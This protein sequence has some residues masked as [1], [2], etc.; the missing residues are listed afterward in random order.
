VG[1]P[2]IVDQFGNEI[3]FSTKP[4]VDTMAELGRVRDPWAGR[5]TSA[6]TP[7]SLAR[8]LRGDAELSD[9]MMLCKQ[10]LRDPHLTACMRNLA[11]SIARLPWEVLPFDESADAK[12]DAKDFGDF[13]N[14]LPF[15]QRMIRQLVYGEFYTFVGVGLKWNL[16]YGLDGF[17]PIDPPRWTWDRPTNSLRLK[18][19]AQ[20]T[21]GEPINARAFVLHNASLEPGTVRDAGLWQKSAWLWLFKNTTW[22]YWVRF[23]ELFG[24]PYIWAFFDRPEDKDSVLEAVTGMAANARGAFPKGTE[25]TIQ[26]AQ[27]Y[28]TTAL[29]DAIIKASEVGMTKLVQGHMLNTDAVSGAGTLAGNAAAD[30]SQENKEGVGTGIKE[31]IQ[32]QLAAPWFLFH[33]GEEQVRAGQIAKFHIRTEPPKDRDKT[34]KTWVSVNQVLASAGRAIDPKQAEEEFAVRTVELQKMQ[35]SAADSGDVDPEDEKK[36]TKKVSHRSAGA[37]AP[38]IQTEGDVR[39]AAT[40]LVAKAAEDF[41]ERIAEIFEQADTIEDGIDALWGG[42]EALDAT[43]LASGLRDVTLTAEAVGRGDVE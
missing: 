5:T 19:I 9:Q 18:T 7:E 42:Y 10:I 30:V 16:D 14:G 17:T 27:R 11:H 32:S 13:L 33:R 24:N 34:A 28:G 39:R 36:E 20:Q 15:L 12:R 8:L 4:P 38:K 35:P 37:K 26:E 3:S 31:T 21:K 43:R 25:I 40:K 1:K 41:S 2:V 6:V 22:A 23:A 29:Y